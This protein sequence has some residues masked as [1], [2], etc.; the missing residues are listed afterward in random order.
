MARIRT[1]KPD[2]WSS[3]Q[4][5]ACSRDARLMFIGMWNFCDD[6]GRCPLAE[7]TIKAQIFPNDDDI[8]FTNIRGWID[9]LSKNGLVL[10]YEVNG[11]QYI[12]VTGWHHQRIDKP[13]LPKHPPP[14]GVSDDNSTNE[15]G[16]VPEQSCPDR[17][18]SERIKDRK[19]ESVE[20]GARPLLKTWEPKKETIEQAKADFGLTADDLKTM[21]LRFGPYYMS[22]GHKR[23]DWDAQFLAWCGDEARTLGRRPAA[24]KADERESPQ[25]P[26]WIPIG[27][28][29]SN[30]IGTDRYDG[31]F[32]GARVIAIEADRAILEAPTKFICDHWQNNFAAQLERA[33]AASYPGVTKVE[34]KAKHK[35]T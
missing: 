1:V 31:W 6:K 16:T 26:K 14:P 2:Y 25:D 27:K 5:M 7:R 22:R 23:A 21:Q 10:I 32:K 13:R 34:I 24:P 9:A 28:N 29:L 8:N 11:R 12:Q 18:V 3:E 20:Q 4:V 30:A 17:I 33:V 35:A 15:A 19:G